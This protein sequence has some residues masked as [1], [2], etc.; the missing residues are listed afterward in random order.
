MSVKKKTTRLK[1]KS[2]KDVAVYL[3]DIYSKKYNDIVY[4][5]KIKNIKLDNISEDFPKWGIDNCCVEKKLNKDEL[6][7]SEKYLNHCFNLLGS[8][9]VINNNMNGTEYI[10]DFYLSSM[11]TICQHIKSVKEEYNF[12]DWQRDFKNDYWYNIKQKSNEITIKEDSGVDIKIPWELARC[13]QLPFLARLYIQT[14]NIEY[15]KEIRNVILDFI[16]F[17]PV[18]YGVNWKCSM[19]IAIRVCNWILAVCICL[20]EDKSH[21][22]DEYFIVLLKK[23]VLEHSIYIRHHLEN[24]KN[25]RGNHYFANIVGL[26][27][28]SICIDNVVHRKNQILFAIKELHKAIKEQFYEDGGNFE[29]SIP[30]HKLTLEM[31]IYGL[32]LIGIIETNDR[33]MTSYIKKYRLKCDESHKIIKKAISFFKDTIKPD[34][35]IY[36]LGDNDSGCLFKLFHYGEFMKKDKY[37]KLY[38]NIHVFEED[39]IWDENELC[40]KELIDLLNACSGDGKS[41]FIFKYFSGFLDLTFHPVSQE[42][43]IKATYSYPELEFVDIQEVKI[44][45]TIDIN[46]LKRICYPD[47]GVYGWKG[48]EFFLEISA[49]G[50]G[51]NGRGGHSH[52]DKL[53]FDLQIAG[54]NYFEDPG[55]YVYTESTTFRNKFRGTMAHNIPYF[56][57]EQNII[58]DGCFRMI[59]RTKCTLL[60]FSK[61]RIVFECRYNE[62]IHIRSIEIYERKIVIKDRSNYKKINSNEFNYFSNG[63]GKLI[64][65]R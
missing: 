58:S 33:E 63:Y 14:H 45:T 53:S 60:E 48:E 1:N 55:T 20:N 40:A 18:G 39:E 64:K 26:I 11:R 4:E 31:S 61:N 36:Q 32:I 51:E 16:A 54:V 15:I 19:D 21:I 13:Q 42:K 8:G 57:V 3:S 23:S 12:I 35:T 52:N 56:G 49:G 41:P 6:Y 29:N 47:F 37:L 2:I 59:Q 65:K 44:H 62:I 30:Y 25:Y 22:L 17:N 28:S 10:P 38:E 27:F 50:V 7:L 5:R 9:W 43:K 34:D 46:G 24:D